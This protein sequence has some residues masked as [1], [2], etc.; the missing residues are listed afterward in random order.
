MRIT[1]SALFGLAVMTAAM[2]GHG[3]GPGCP[4]P[5]AT[6]TVAIAIPGVV[7]AGTKIEVIKSGFTGTRGT[8][9][10]TRRQ[11]D[12]HG[13]PGE[14]HHAHRQGHGRHHH[15]PR[16]HQRPCRRSLRSPY[17]KCSTPSP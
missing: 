12:F 4:P 10:T 16:E 15:V 7:A 1:T 6:E 3:S 9:W 2:P 14:S 11:P 17:Q 8:D 5:A 13:D